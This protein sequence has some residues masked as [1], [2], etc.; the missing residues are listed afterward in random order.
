MFFLFL[1]AD[2]KLG[3]VLEEEAAM[4]PKQGIRKGSRNPELIRSIGKYSR[5]Q[6]YHKRV[7]ILLAGRFK[8][9]RE[10]FL[11]Q[12]PSGLLLVTVHANCPMLLPRQVDVYAVNV[13]N[14]DDKYFLKESQKKKKKGEGEFFIETV[15]KEKRVLPRRNDQKNVD[16]ALIKSIES[17]LDLNAYLGASFSLKAGVKPH[18]LVF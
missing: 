6:M 18:E 15:K 4:A 13:D 16:S 10:V 9:K 5:L 7:F 12:L 14:F 17:I 8:G 2:F 1:P 11:K 3:F